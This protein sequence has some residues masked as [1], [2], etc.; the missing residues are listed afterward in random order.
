ME[1]RA[2]DVDHNGNLDIGHVRGYQRS[3]TKYYLHLQ[4]E[5]FIRACGRNNSAV[6]LGSVQLG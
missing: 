3:R 1:D 4:S 2:E 6:R 5:D